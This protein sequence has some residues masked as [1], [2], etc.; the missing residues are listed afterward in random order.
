MG[1]IWLIGPSVS[2]GYWNKPSEAFNTWLKNGEGPYFKTGDLG[3]ISDNE[4]Y[5]TGR[6]KELIIIRGKNYYPTDI[7]L[8]V[9]ES[10]TAIR[11]GCVAAFSD[12]VNETEHLTIA[13][14]IKNTAMNPDLEKIAFEIKRIILSKHGIKAHAIHLVK[15]KQLPKTTSGKMQRL[16]T[17]DLINAQKIEVLYLLREEEKISESAHQIKKFMVEEIARICKIPIDKVKTDESI[18][19]FG[20]ESIQLPGLLQ[21]IE[22][23]AGKKIKIEHLVGQPTIQ[24]IVDNLYLTQPIS[25]NKVQQTMEQSNSTKQTFILPDFDILN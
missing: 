19:N 23:Y 15:A 2:K 3:F 6:I 7:E 8:S 17:K 13:A 21:R 10:H 4:L 5:I 1:E 20:I 25:D 9:I 22:N 18:F 14:E 24:S 16:K 12:V 11:K